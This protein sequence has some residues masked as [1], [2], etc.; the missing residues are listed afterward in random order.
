M[1]EVVSWKKMY[2]T[3]QF[4]K[5]TNVLYDHIFVSLQAPDSPVG[6][7]AMRAAARLNMQINKTSSKGRCHDILPQRKCYFMS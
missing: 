4:H 3:T 6:A 1:C 5:K 7:R 2:F